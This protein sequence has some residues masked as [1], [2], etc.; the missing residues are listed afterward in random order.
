MSENAI[1]FAESC[2]EAEEKM[3]EMT[4]HLEETV[5]ANRKKLIDEGERI[6]VE[7]REKMTSDVA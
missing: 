2:R 1:G 7:N 6:V 3:G 5:E 4:T